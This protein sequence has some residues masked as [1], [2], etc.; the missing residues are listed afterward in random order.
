MIWHQKLNASGNQTQTQWSF[1]AE[2]WLEVWDTLANL[3]KMMK[4]LAGRVGLSE[5]AK[6]TYKGQLHNVRHNPKIPCI[7]KHFS[8][9][10][11]PSQGSNS[12]GEAALTTWLSWLSKN[13]KQTARLKLR[14]VRAPALPSVVQ[15]VITS[16][17]M[18]TNGKDDRI[19]LMKNLRQN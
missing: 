15:S 5:S 10:N 16:E 7:D 19:G 9:L 1:A 12:E 14:T 17:S 18:R 6:N 11:S 3:L 4:L 13:K 2:T 8:S